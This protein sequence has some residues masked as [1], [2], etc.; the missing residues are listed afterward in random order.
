MFKTR[1]LLSKIGLMIG[2]VSVL[3]ILVAPMASVHAES[4]QPVVGEPPP[5]FVTGAETCWAIQAAYLTA[6][7]Y[8]KD[9]VLAEFNKCLQDELTR[10]QIWEGQVGDYW[11]RRSSQIS[12]SFEF[13][14]KIALLG[15]VLNAMGYAAQRIAYETAQLIL[16][17]GQGD[18]PM[19]WNQP[20]G[21]WIQNVGEQ[22][23]SMFISQL[24]EA[25]GTYTEDK[26]GTKISFCTKPNPLALS[27]SLSGVQPIEMMKP[28]C[29]LSAMASNFS[30]IAD[31]VE[32]GDALRIQ[33]AQFDPSANDLAIGIEINN[34]KVQGELDAMKNQLAQ[35]QESQGM[36]PIMDAISWKLKY[37]S[38]MANESLKSMDPVTV[39]YQNQKDQESYMMD[40]FWQTG[41]EGIAAITVATFANTM[42]VGILQR[43]FKQDSSPAGD[44]INATP[45]QM[46]IKFTALQNADASGD[47]VDLYE[48]QSFAKAL[49][50]YIVPNFS[51]TED[52]DILSEL[53]TCVT[54]RGRWSCAMDQALTVAISA[55]TKD[56]ALTVGRAAGIGQEGASYSPNGQGLHA[57]WELIPESD[58]KNNT[59]PACA[60]RAYCAG[61]LKKMRL[62]RILPIGWEMAANSIYNLKKNGK[63]ILLGEVIRNFYNCNDKGEIDK[64]HPWCH[65]VDPNWIL[66]S[67]KYQCRAKGYGDTIMPGTGTRF[68]DCGDVVSCLGT[69]QNNECTQGYGYCLAERPVYKFDSKT[70]EP[71]FA[72]CRTYSGPLGMASYLRNSVDRGHCSEENMGCAWYATER[73]VTSTQT[74]DGLW[75]GTVTSGPRVYYD[76]TVKPCTAEGCSKVY[77]FEPG[78]QAL[79]LVQNGSF[80]SVQKDDQG[81]IKSL[82]GWHTGSQCSLDKSVLSDNSYDKV[83]N[84]SM[85][86]AS[87]KGAEQDIQISQNRYY[88]LSFYLK[89]QA[90]SEKDA[91]TVT[92]YKTVGGSQQPITS[93]IAAYEDCAAS[94]NQLIFN[95]TASDSW[96]RTT[97][98]F[99]SPKDATS[100]KLVLA[101]APGVLRYDAIQ[102]EEGQNPTLFGEGVAAQLAESYLKIAPDEYKCTGNDAT[103]NTA[104][105][106]FARVCTQTDVGCQGYK[107]TEDLTAPEIPATLSTK[108]L[109]PAICAG[110]GEYRKLAS[111]FDLVKSA[112]KQYDDPNDDT[113][114]YF[115]PSL[116]AQCSLEEVGCEAFTSL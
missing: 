14:I 97:C 54:P 2:L 24:D 34:R 92:F 69:N 57:D 79:N 70:C 87:C 26:L 4:S 75:V 73:Y 32:S 104:C 67:P 25:I 43:I 98:K 84:L 18:Q 78:Q 111:S 35:R 31:M 16:T 42:V 56:G 68:E 86:G 115:I 110:Y 36:K 9:M 19:F 41:L 91:S 103:D 85:D 113:I 107:D 49:G 74:A 114:A 109:C 12:Q 62:A 40:A 58:I 76:G 11:Y 53:S 80:E 116:A 21:E 94:G 33:K 66:T 8:D 3:V 30:A 64:D 93:N 60:Q 29:T 65:L 28:T 82:D 1:L 83:S 71:Q 89:T 72:S 50:D 81:S 48:R 52:K 39:A 46:K 102:L 77:R 27:M 99:V 17:G 7:P 101:G 37:P 51:S 108:D 88:V 45:S 20:I 10:A 100:L 38:V 96:V 61:N 55:G 59:D 5:I 44:S 63:Y 13:K 112:D 6:S 90:K 22:S 106:R 105:K 15:G 47:A 95:K 23:S